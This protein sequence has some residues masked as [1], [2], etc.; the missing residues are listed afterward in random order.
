VIA[1]A[2]LSWTAV[3][4]AQSLADVARREE[5]RRKA[6]GS[7]G[8]VYTND[9]LRAEPPPS[10]VPAPGTTPA[11]E[12]PGKPAETPAATDATPAEA[13]KPAAQ[14]AGSETPKTE[15]AWRK[16]IAT[17]REG[18]ERS[19]LLADAL[20]SQINGLTTDFENR[21]DP[22]QR[23]VIFAN[24]QKA[25]AELDRVKKE[26]EQHQKAVATIQEEA[27]RAGVPAGWVR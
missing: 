6:V 26:I 9:H 27:R 5:E 7:S 11:P 8:K 13:G 17:E 2:L 4:S 3:A 24:R 15:E 12:T 23:N 25:L 18:A 21:S 16:R 10:G 1:C 19:K 22:A 14:A 20:Q